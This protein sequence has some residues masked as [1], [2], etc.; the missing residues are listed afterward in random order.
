[1]SVSGHLTR[2]NGAALHLSLSGLRYDQSAPNDRLYTTRN[3]N[4]AGSIA[5]AVRVA[6]IATQEAP[7]VRGTNP[8]SD[9]AVT[10]N[11]LLRL[12]EECRESVEVPRGG[13][14][15]MDSY[16]SV[17]NYDAFVLA[18]QREITS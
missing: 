15:G 16:M 2:L 8:A 9:K 5:N 11:M 3:R 1:M 14:G 4:K 13:P 6:Q 12:L 7:E 17:V 18:L 10:V